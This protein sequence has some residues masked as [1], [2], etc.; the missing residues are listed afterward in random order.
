[1]KTLLARLLIGN[2]DFDVLVVAES[3]LLYLG[4]RLF[5]VRPLAVIGGGVA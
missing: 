4:P 1:M 3:V 2:V 5:G